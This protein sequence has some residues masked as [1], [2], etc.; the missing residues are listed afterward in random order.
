M[1]LKQ[2]SWNAVVVRKSWANLRAIRAFLRDA[3]PQDVQDANS[4]SHSPRHGQTHE[5]HAGRFT[6][7]GN[8]RRKIHSSETE[9]NLHLDRDSHADD[10]ATE[11]ADDGHTILA[12]VL[13]DT[14]ERGLWIELNTKEHEKNPAVELQAMMIPWHAVLAVVAADDF[15]AAAEQVEKLRFTLSTSSR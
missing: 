10:Y 9:R 13:D 15:G 6:D 3:A 7:S 4:D 8:G 11:T 2:N 12:R 14:D 1:R 5:A